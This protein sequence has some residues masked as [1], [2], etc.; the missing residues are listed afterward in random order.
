MVNNIFFTGKKSIGKS[1]AVNKAIERL[2]VNVSGFKTFKEQIISGN[3]SKVYICDVNRAKYFDMANCVALIYDEKAPAVLTETFNTFGVSCLQKS[4]SQ[5]IIMD[6]LGFLE[7]D[8]IEFGKAV[9]NCIESDKP[10]LGALRK[11]KPAQWV[12]D[13]LKCNTEI[14]ELDGINNNQMIDYAVN[15]L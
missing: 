6:E 4:D 7:K 10:V 14:I 8:A 9:R 12:M 15:L 2:G 1:Y 3:L 5:I 11:D 13:A